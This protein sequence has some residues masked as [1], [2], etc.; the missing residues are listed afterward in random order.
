MD[1]SGQCFQN[2]GRAGIITGFVELVGEREELRRIGAVASGL[3]PTCGR[4]RR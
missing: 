4:C 3:G 1:V 2:P